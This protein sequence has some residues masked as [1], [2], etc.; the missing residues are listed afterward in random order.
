[1]NAGWDSGGA[2]IDGDVPAL[3]ALTRE[4]LG[5]QM[6]EMYEPVIDQPLDPRCG[7]APRP[8]AGTRCARL[9]LPC[10]S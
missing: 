6:Q 2:R 1:M 9:R 3:D 5:R 8:G 10:L 4:R 7:T